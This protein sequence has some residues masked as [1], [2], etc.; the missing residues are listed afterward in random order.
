MDYWN[1]NVLRFSGFMKENLNSNSI[2]N[3]VAQQLLIN[4]DTKK[5]I[6]EDFKVPVLY[7]DIDTNNKTISS[8]VAEGNNSNNSG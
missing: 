3:F 8:N 6:T 5:N 1:K 4:T 2:I 7:V